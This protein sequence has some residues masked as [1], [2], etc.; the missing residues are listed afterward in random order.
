MDVTEQKPVVAG[1]EKPFVIGLDLGGTNAVF[2]VLI[3]VVRYLPPILLR[4][5]LIRQSKI[6]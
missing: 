3:S 1:L 6:L 4:H 5:R 2:G